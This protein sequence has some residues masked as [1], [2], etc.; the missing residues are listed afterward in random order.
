[1]SA[2][3]KQFHRIG[4]A[5]VLVTLLAGCE[6]VLTDA[7]RRVRV[8]DG[9]NALVSHCKETGPV[10]GSAFGAGAQ[11]TTAKTRM[12]LQNRAAELGATD[13]VMT[14]AERS[15]SGVG[16]IIKGVAYNCQPV[17]REY[18]RTEGIITLVSAPTAETQPDIQSD[19]FSFGVT[20]RFRAKEPPVAVAL[21]LKTT[22]AVCASG[23]TF[24][25]G[26]F[27]AG[28]PESHERAECLVGDVARLLLRY[29][30]LKKLTAKESFTMMLGTH[31]AEFRTDSIRSFVDAVQAETQ[32]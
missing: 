10:S 27:E 16:A 13:V 9:K 26:T 28:S 3:E 21:L 32:L 1:L 19:E 2:R 20:A 22:E 23:V 4:S 5:L 8:H 24:P 25:A 29:D 31:N 30:D 12:V 17:Y 15:A 6:V 14:S 11:D 18:S 7:G